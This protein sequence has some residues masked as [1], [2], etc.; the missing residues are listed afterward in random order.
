MKKVELV[1]YLNKLEGFKTASKNFHFS[2]KN[3]NEHQVI[4]EV[5][6]MLSEYQ[7]E[8]AEIFQGING[9]FG[10]NT[11]KGIPYSLKSS[12]S[13]IQDILKETI[14]FYNKVD[15][16][17]FAGLKSVLEE[18][19]GR[20]N[21]QSYL[22]DLSLKEDFKRNFKNKINESRKKQHSNIV[23][24]TLTNGELNDIISEAIQRVFKRTF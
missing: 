4:D 16:S 13:F 2:A 22:L 19:I 15:G 8:V 20:L 23:E 18:F 11:I 1:S 5:T 24:Y 6:S 7:D 21:K 12:K 10:K 9:Q 17:E 14:S 3:L